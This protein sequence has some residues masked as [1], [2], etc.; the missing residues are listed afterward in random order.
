MPAR[1]SW[2]VLCTLFAFGGQRPQTL[3]QK[4]ETSYAQ[5]DY[6][7]ALS[8]L[9]FWE[10]IPRSGGSSGG[11]TYGFSSKATF[12]DR[13][14]PATQIFPKVVLAW[15]AQ[16]LT[17]AQEAERGGKTQE[18]AELC[19][20]TLMEIREHEWAHDPGFPDQSRI[21]DQLGGLFERNT[22]SAWS[23]WQAQTTPPLERVMSGQTWVVPLL[24]G[25]GET[26]RKATFKALI[27]QASEAEGRMVA[28]L[29]SSDEKEAHLHE[30]VRAMLERWATWMDHGRE[31]KNP[32]E[33][34]A[35]AFALPQASTLREGEQK[36]GLAPG[37]LRAFLSPYYDPSSV[38]AHA[39]SL[40]P[41]R[42]GDR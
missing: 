39:C 31:W 16:M 10:T 35:P 8:D 34:A 25:A 27:V 1:L 24:A 12:L 21:E 28:A 11:N 26:E 6:A 42:Y 29:S 7:Q 4:V 15:K 38:D 36:R 41:H 32:L 22:R 19:R 40:P 5:G 9:L 17:R 30:L 14:D 2:G 18:A 3:L 20:T 23:A 13:Q 37:T 33:M